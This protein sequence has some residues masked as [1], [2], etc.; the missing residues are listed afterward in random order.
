MN[1]R[2]K[3]I[4]GTRYLVSIEPCPFLRKETDHVDYSH[5]EGYCGTCDG[6]DVVERI[7]HIIG[8]TNDLD[9]MLIG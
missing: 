9:Y 4:N 6:T 1:Q 8:K 7:I 3:E 5:D 2:I